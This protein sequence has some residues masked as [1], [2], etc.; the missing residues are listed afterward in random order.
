M[1][2]SFNRKHSTSTEIERT[3]EVNY[4]GISVPIEIKTNGHREL[5]SAMERQLI[6]KYTREPG[7]GGFGVY[8]V[9][10]FGAYLTQAALDGRRPMTPQELQLSA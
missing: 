5:W 10:W 9:L 7:T 2:S 1:K 6:K 4:G 8:L 3:S